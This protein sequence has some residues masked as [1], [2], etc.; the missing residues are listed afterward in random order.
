[1]RTVLPN[2]K[3]AK[4][5][6]FLDWLREHGVEPNDC[7]RVDMNAHNMVVYCYKRNARGYKYIL[8]DSE[9][10]EQNGKPAKEEPRTIE[11]KRRYWVGGYP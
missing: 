10:D 3:V 2:H 1:M 7:Y 6:T 11:Y 9:D 5:T 8:V 4:E